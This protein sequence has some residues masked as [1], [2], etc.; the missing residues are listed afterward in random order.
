MEYPILKMNQVVK[1]YGNHTA[2]DGVSFEVPKGSVFGLL[3]PNG[4]GKSTLLKIVA[5]LEYDYNG[6]LHLFHNHIKNKKEY[7]E[8]RSDVGYLPQDVS[9]YF[10]YLRIILKT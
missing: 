7:E 1:Q 9:D 8:F 3:G 5:G 4:A 6:E 2:V 10:L